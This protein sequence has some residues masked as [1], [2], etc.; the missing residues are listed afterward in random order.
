MYYLNNFCTYYKKKGTNI[1]GIMRFQI[2]SFPPQKGVKTSYI[3]TLY[4][5]ANI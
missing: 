1:E 2:C 3:D 4:D 5:Y